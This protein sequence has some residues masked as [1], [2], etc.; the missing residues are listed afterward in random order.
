MAEQPRRPCS[1]VL[2]NLG[3]GFVDRGDPGGGPHPKSRLWSLPLCHLPRRLVSCWTGRGKLPVPARGNV[4]RDSN[5]G[6]RGIIDGEGGHPKDTQQHNYYE[7]YECA[8]HFGPS[9]SECAQ[10]AGFLPL[11]PN[12]YAVLVFFEDL[13]S[14]VLHDHKCY[15]TTPYGG[16][17]SRPNWA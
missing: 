17:S 6:D 5:S 14:R 1:F 16:S 10:P 12:C 2:V 8:L 3:R 9:L 4:A 11:R 7:P 13:G 15:T